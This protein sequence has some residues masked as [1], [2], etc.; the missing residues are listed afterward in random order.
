MFP[1]LV[2]GFYCETDRGSA[3]FVFTASLSKGKPR[4]RM[5]SYIV[6]QSYLTNNGYINSMVKEL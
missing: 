6:L 4:S 1:E 5:V 3:G 2:E